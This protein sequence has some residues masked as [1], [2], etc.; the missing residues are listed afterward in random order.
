MRN[1]IT[2]LKWNHQLF[3][4]KKTDTESNLSDGKTAEWKHRMACDDFIWANA[5][6]YDGI[7]CSSH[8]AK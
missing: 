3:K 6:K 4:T 8:D 5:I 1:L 7:F 2:F